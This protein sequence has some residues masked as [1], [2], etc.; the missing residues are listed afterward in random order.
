MRRTGNFDAF[1][2]AIILPAIDLAQS[3]D[4]SRFATVEERHVV[5]GCIRTPKIDLTNVNVKTS[6]E[7]DVVVSHFIL[8][9]PNTTL[10]T[11]FQISVNSIYN[12]QA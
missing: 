5:E 12:L 6:G 1:G 3:D 2:I 9:D 10:V 7:E 4:S 8:E 11:N